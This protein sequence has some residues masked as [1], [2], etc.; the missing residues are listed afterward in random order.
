MFVDNVYNL[1]MANFLDSLDEPILQVIHTISE[2]DHIHLLQSLHKA[3]I[4]HL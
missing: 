1:D 2:D 4:C 3:S